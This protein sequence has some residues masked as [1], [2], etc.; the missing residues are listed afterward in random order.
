MDA[1]DYLKTKRA[2]IRAVEKQAEMSES[3]DLLEFE[4][5][6]SV[7]HHKGAPV[8]LSASF[9]AAVSNSLHRHTRNSNT[10]S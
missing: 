5:H 4:L 8:G 9:V 2:L 6:Q 10:N 7:G 1:D 3:I